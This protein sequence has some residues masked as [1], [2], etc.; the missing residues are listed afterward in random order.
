MK[1]LVAFGKKKMFSK[2]PPF[3]SQ[4][5]KQEPIQA[6]YPDIRLD[7]YVLDF[8]SRGQHCALREKKRQIVTLTN[9]GCHKAQF[10]IKPLFGTGEKDQQKWTLNVDPKEGVIKKVC[11]LGVIRLESSHLVFS[12]AQ[13]QT[14][15]VTFEL[16]IFQRAVCVT[17][18]LMIEVTGGQYC[19]MNVFNFGQADL[20]FLLS[21]HRILATLE[22]NAMP[23]GAL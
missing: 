13:G 6:S 10:V 23:A 9:I 19:E 11:D 15:E 22:V 21:G 2:S 18:L 8:G 3:P 17:E 4:P 5:K 20:V 16:E 1:R 12:R 7:Q 14:I